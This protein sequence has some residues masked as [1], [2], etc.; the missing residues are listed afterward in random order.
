MQT[1]PVM[2]FAYSSFDEAPHLCYSVSWIPDGKG[3]DHM[4]KQTSFRRTLE[5]SLLLIAAAQ[6]SLSPFAM[7]FRIS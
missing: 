7:E 6:F 4:E 3:E 1:S 2:L 5:L